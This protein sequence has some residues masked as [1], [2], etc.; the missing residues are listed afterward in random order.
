MLLVPTTWMKNLNEDEKAEK[1]EH[2]V[3]H[4]HFSIPISLGKIFKVNSAT[5]KSNNFG[6]LIKRCLAFFL[7]LALNNFHLILI[8]GIEQ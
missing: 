7:L 5:I 6:V 8:R 1:A 2:K 3:N 4:T